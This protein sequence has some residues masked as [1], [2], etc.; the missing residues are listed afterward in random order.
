MVSIGCHARELDEDFFSDGR[1]IGAVGEVVFDWLSS[2]IILIERKRRESQ[3]IEQ[4]G[5]N[6]SRFE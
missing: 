4:S 6:V 3:W 2:S 1:G 5:G